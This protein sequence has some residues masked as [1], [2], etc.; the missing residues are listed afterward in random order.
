M[1]LPEPQMH[2]NYCRR[3]WCL[4]SGR[5]RVVMDNLPAHSSGIREAIEAVGATVVY[6]SPLLTRFFPIENCWAK[7]S[8]NFYAHEQREPMFS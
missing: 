8:R 5:G 4:I 2:W 6:L 7:K 3:Y 1:T